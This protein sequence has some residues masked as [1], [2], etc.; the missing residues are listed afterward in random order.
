MMVPLI[1]Y[2]KEKEWFSLFFYRI[3]SIK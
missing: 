2:K 1:I 3:E